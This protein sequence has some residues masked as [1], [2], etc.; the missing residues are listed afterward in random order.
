[1][2]KGKLMA[3]ILVILFCVVVCITVGFVGGYMVGVKKETQT[4][5]AQIQ[6]SRDDYFLVEGLSVND[7]NFRGQYTFTVTEQTKLEWRYTEITLA[8]LDVGDTVAITYQGG[9]RETAPAGIEKVVKIQ[10]LDDEK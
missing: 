8:D 1:M 5:Y 2:K 7:I 3:K 10:L 9:I 6:E 4:F